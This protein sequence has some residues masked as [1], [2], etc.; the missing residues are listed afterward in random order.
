[1]VLVNRR[2]RRVVNEKAHYNERGRI[3]TVY[4][5]TTKQYENNVLIQVYDDAVANNPGNGVKY[6]VPYPGQVDG[7]R[8][9]REHPRGVGSGHRLNGSRPSLIARVGFGSRTTLRHSCAT[10]SNGSTSLRPT[11]ST[12]TS[13]GGPL[14]ASAATA[15]WV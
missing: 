10:R 3:H 11:E 13:G 1:M 8:A 5:A 4:D 9:G 6:P 12:M 7:P 14:L 15:S 2:G